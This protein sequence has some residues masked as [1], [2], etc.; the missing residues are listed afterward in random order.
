MAAVGATLRVV[1]L[2]G[3]P[4]VGK[5]ETARRLVRRYRVPAALIDTDTMADVYP[6]VA[7]PRTYAL[8]SRNLRACLSAYREWGARVVVIS[9]VL[10]PGRSLHALGDLLADP[11]LNWVFYGLRAEPGELAARIRADRKVQEAAGRLSWS[12]LDDEVPDVPKVRLVDTG[13]VPLARVVDAIAAAEAEDLPAET[14]TAPATTITAPAPTITAPALTSAAPAGPPPAGQRVLVGVSRAEDACRV[15][16]SAAGMPAPVAAA[17]AAD[18]VDAE[19]RGQ[20]SHGLLRLPEY[21]AAIAD[22]DLDPL[23]QPVVHRTGDSAVVID[24]RRAPGVVVRELVATQFALGAR[25]VAVRASG[26]LGRLGPLAREV[27]DHGLVLIGFVNYAG[28]GTKVAPA[29]GSVG[30]WATNPIVL[31]CPGADG[32]PVVVDMSTSSVAEGRVRDAFTS[33]Q[34]LPPGLLTD[35]AGGVVTDPALLYTDPPRAAITPLGGPAAHKGHALAAFVEAM[36]GAVAGAGHVGAPGPPGNGGL[37]V[38]FPVTAFGRSVPEVDAALGQ[39]E[40]HLRGAAPDG[41]RLPGRNPAATPL[42]DTV[43]VPTAL[44]RSIGEALLERS[45]S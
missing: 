35:P 32:R 2:T 7:E 39:I 23:A 19:R 10:L 37:F 21:L 24:G 3:A 4:G 14:I 30:T 20:R 45:T 33:G 27:A 6:W 42:P 18:L 16:L 38:A 17:T 41:P 44:W 22:G 28:R 31:G 15:A 29:G 9:G 26:H 43:S 1:V 36:V 11:G 40:G 13:G 34:S 25:T 12:F 5:T 8:I